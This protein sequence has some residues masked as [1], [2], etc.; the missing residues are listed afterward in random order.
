M[1]GRVAPY[2][3]VGIAVFVVGSTLIGDKSLSHLIHL[4]QELHELETAADKLTQQIEQANATITRVKEDP[5]FLEQRAREEL[6]LSKPGEIIYI[7][8]EGPVV[9]PVVRAEKSKLDYR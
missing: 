9:R 8:P 3:I 2:I 1:I 7:F 6:A 5:L 4:K